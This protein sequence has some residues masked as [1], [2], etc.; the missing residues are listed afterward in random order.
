MSLAIPFPFRSPA[1]TAPSSPGLLARLA[2]RHL[3]RVSDRDAAWLERGERIDL[4]TRWRE[5]VE[6]LGQL[7]HPI[8]TPLGG[9]TKAGLPRVVHVE[10]GPPVHLIVQL[11]GAQVV[12][13]LEHYS[14][15]LA[16]ALGAWRLWFSSRGDGFVRVDLVQSD[17]LG[18]VV[19]FLPPHELGQLVFGVDEWGATVSMPLEWLTHCVVQG[20]TRSGKSAWSYQ[21]LAQLAHRRDVEVAGIDPTGLL[22]RPFGPHPRGWRVL[23]TDDP[24]ARYEAAMAGV[25]AEMDARI[26]AMP[27]RRDTVEISPGC[28]LIVVV[29]EEWAGLARLVGHKRDRPSPVH[30]LVSRLLAEG[31]KA[32]IRVVTIVQRAEADVVGAFERDQALTRLSFAVNDDNTLKMLHPDIPKEQAEQHATSPKGVALLTTPGMPLTRI[33]GPWIGGYGDYVDLVTGR[34]PARPPPDRPPPTARLRRVRPD[35]RQSAAPAARNE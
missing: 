32:G 19:P 4:A 15:E 16:G 14:E 18:Q 29:L 35:H 2:G 1:A 22:L 17:P 10:P 24:L 26:A 11:R 34:S 6:D 3:Q 5:A 20:A 25:V 33:R 27:A 31:A 9:M 13:D 12:A 21:L 7:G 28:P 8:T 23:G 30:K